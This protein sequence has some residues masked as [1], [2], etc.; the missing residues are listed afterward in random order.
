[1]DVSG[2]GTMREYYTLYQFKQ[3]QNNTPQIL[4]LDDSHLDRVHAVELQGKTVY[5]IQSSFVGSLCDRTFILKAFYFEQNSL[6]PAAIFTEE[7]QA[8]QDELSLNNQCR[9]GGVD[10]DEIFRISN[11]QKYID[12]MMMPENENADQR[13]QRYEKTAEGYQKTGVVK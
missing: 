3:N 10:S 4:D 9:W 11:S 5:L 6:K 13:Y 7:A 12:I 1:M 2:G 8:K